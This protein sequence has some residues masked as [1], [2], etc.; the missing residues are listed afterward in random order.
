[1]R[2]L[3]FTFLLFHL[4]ASAQNFTSKHFQIQKL[5]PNVYAAI[6]KSGGYAICNAGVIDLGEEVLVFDPFLTPEAAQDLNSFIKTNLKKPV[7]YVVNSHSHND[8]IRGTQVFSNATVIGTSM[9]RQAILESEPAD[10]KDEAAAAPKRVRYYDSIPKAQDAWQAEEDLLWKGYFNGM[11]R[12]IPHLKTTPP[13]LLFSDS[14]TITGTLSDVQ[15]ISF[16]DGHTPSDLFLYL[17]KEKI[18]FMGDL[19][20]IDM[21]PWLGYSKPPNW[22]SYLNKVQALGVNTYIPG[23]GPTGTPA[24]INTMIGYIEK[25]LQLG[26]QK[27]ENPKLEINLPDEY[28]HWHLR[29]FFKFNVSFASKL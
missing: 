26:Q 5:A 12:S 8:H 24:E 28:K 20:F 19:L 2:F 4:S 21:H 3:F 27:K 17:P 11:A 15:L 13:N 9:I 25:L 18:A 14:L 6:A 7:R 1:M 16:G 29:N 23:H 10:I 22:I